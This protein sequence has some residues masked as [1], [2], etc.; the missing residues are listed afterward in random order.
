MQRMSSRHKL[1]AAIRC[2]AHAREELRALW[3][4]TS[5]KAPFDGAEHRLAQV[6]EIIEERS[7]SAQSDNAFQAWLETA[8]GHQSAPLPAQVRGLLVD[9]NLRLA[10]IEHEI[11]FESLALLISLDDLRR[12][13]NE[14]NQALSV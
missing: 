13:V 10:A 11:P 9:Q 2:L 14:A 6:A 8:G 7:K 5:H 4:D 3:D 1:S 12:A